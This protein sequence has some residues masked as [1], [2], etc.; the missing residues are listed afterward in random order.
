MFVFLSSASHHHNFPLCFAGVHTTAGT[1][2]HSDGPQA[3]PAAPYPTTS[4][5]GPKTGHT[6]GQPGRGPD[7][8]L[9]QNLPA[10]QQVSSQPSAKVTFTADPRASPRHALTLL[11]PLFHRR[12]EPTYPSWGAGRLP[13]Q[14]TAQTRPQML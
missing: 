8:G 3:A 4:L 7:T 5:P 10:P 14:T 1:T 6:G 12:V 11:R 13:P 2:F 9:S